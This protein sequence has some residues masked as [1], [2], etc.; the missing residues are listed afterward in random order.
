MATYSHIIICANN[1]A[2]LDMVALALWSTVARVRMQVLEIFLL[3]KNRAQLLITKNFGYSRGTAKAVARDLSPAIFEWNF[4][5][6]LHQPLI[7]KA[8][9]ISWLWEL[10]AR[11]RNK[12]IFDKLV[13]V[14]VRY[15]SAGFLSETSYICSWYKLCYHWHQ[16]WHIQMSPLH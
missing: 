10:M 12:M 3:L 4:F 14:M 16:L 15:V 2:K 5:T 6:G 11:T 9:S 13:P 7:L 8:T 1:S